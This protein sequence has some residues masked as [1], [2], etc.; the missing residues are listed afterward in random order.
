MYCA[1]RGKHPY[2]H[3][4]DFW[5]EALQAIRKSNT[6]DTIKRNVARPLRQVRTWRGCQSAR[7]RPRSFSS[8]PALVKT[9]FRQRLPL[10][11][12]SRP[13]R[14]RSTP[15]CAGNRPL[16][17]PTFSMA[18]AVFTG[19]VD[20]STMILLDVDTDAIMRAAPSLHRTAPT[21]AEPPR[22]VRGRPRCGSKRE[23]SC[24]TAQPTIC[25]A[26][27]YVRSAAFPAPTP[28]VLVGVFTLRARDRSPSDRSRR[29]RT[30]VS[31]SV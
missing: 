30:R 6:Q 21:A 24:I 13:P 19:T 26:D 23:R 28:R 11:L 9:P 22:R 16:R 29:L 1:G 3:N 14:R 20:F 25:S 5:S 7:S 15:I 4:H 31:N 12:T 18:S 27:Q 8:A 17:T 10:K 2:L